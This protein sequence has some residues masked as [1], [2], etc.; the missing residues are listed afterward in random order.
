MLG[1]DRHT[2]PNES[3]ELASLDEKIEEKVPLNLYSGRGRDKEIGRTG[4]RVATSAP[5]QAPMGASILR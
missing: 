4:G 5:W 3:D 1:D 2:A